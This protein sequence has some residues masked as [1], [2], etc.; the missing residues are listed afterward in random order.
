[1][2]DEVDEDKNGTIEFEEFLS[3][4]ANRITN[5]DKIQK[6]FKVF[7]KNDDGWAK[8]RI[9]TEPRH[10]TTCISD[11]YL[12]W[13]Y[14]RSCR[15]WV[16]GFLE[17]R[18]ALWWIKTVTTIHYSERC[19]PLWQGY[20]SLDGSEPAQKLEKESQSIKR[21]VWC[22]PVL[23]LVSHKMWQTDTGS[24]CQCRPFK[25]MFFGR[26]LR[27]FVICA[28]PQRNHLGLL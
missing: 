5:S 24:F 6:V 28:L 8:K 14:Q 20:S 9:L 11:S 13:S 18:W 26:N 12:Q 7:D 22:V 21:S 3:M 1:M 27:F 2:V 17:R 15:T 10:L 4:M 19:I 23:P 25:T 16:K